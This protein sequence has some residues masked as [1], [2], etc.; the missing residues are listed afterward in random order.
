M[1][2]AVLGLGPMGQAMARTFLAHGYST[3]VWNRTAS[4]A[5]A[6]VAEGAVR[7]STVEEAL[8]A[9]VIV[10][11]LTDYQ[12]MYDILGSADLSGRVLVNLSSDT[13]SRS[14]EAAA[15]VA[16]RGGSLVVGGIMVPSPLVGTDQSY[17]FYS[18][19]REVF[20]GVS[21]VL[22]VLG[23]PDYRGED[24][25]LAQLFYQAQLD[26]FLTS[27]SA[28]LHASAL[29]GSAGVAAS[30]FVPYAVENFQMMEY[31]LADAAAGIDAG[32]YPGDQANVI[33][34]GATADHIVGASRDA[35]IDVG[36]PGAVKAHYDGAIA[37]GNGRAGWTSLIEVI[38]KGA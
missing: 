22:A 28:F 7:A 20:D 33:M 32:E 16:E 23:R 15:W 30:D 2:V 4:R 3:T 9:D 13:P 18:G 25:A 24:P 14:R 6:L 36:L 5:D 12:A 10:L 34:M 26:I 31:Y 11:S 1:N 38:K 21:A 19:P 27:L 35:G 8:R 37:A 17:V 29:V